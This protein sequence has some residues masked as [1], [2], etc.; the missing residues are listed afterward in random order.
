M[1]CLEANKVFW[2][3]VDQIKT[4]RFSD[5]EKVSR[6]WMVS[7]HPGLMVDFQWAGCH[8]SLQ[9]VLSGSVSVTYRNILVLK[10][11][12]SCP[13]HTTSLAWHTRWS[14]WR[15]PCR[16]QCL[17]SGDTPPPTDTHMWPHPRETWRTRRNSRT[18]W[19]GK[20]L[21]RHWFSLVW[22]TKCSTGERARTFGPNWYLTPLGINHDFWA[23][24]HT[25]LPLPRP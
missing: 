24:P 4:V 7:K 6:S 8:A 11:R 13:L 18:P 10:P 20:D 14:K 3:V 9:I 5:R 19:I 17:L 1:W 12:P 25:T 21:S 22:F 23:C 2:F 15:C 16:R